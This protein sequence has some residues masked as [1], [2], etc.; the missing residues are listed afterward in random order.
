MK[1]RSLSILQNTS[2]VFYALWTLVC[3]LC[4]GTARATDVDQVIQEKAHRLV[5]FLDVNTSETLDNT[6]TR[7]NAALELLNQLETSIPQ[8]L[9]IGYIAAE[10]ASIESKLLATIAYRKVYPQLVSD[11]EDPNSYVE[12]ESRAPLPLPPKPEHISENYRL[13]WE[14]RLLIPVSPLMS[15][16]GEDVT[17]L[18]AIEGIRNTKSLMVYEWLIRRDGLLGESSPLYFNDLKWRQEVVSSLFAFGTAESTRVGL[19]LLPLINN[20]KD[21]YLSL[22]DS[23]PDV[24]QFE[25]ERL[26]IAARD[27][28]Q[29]SSKLRT[30]R[31]RIAEVGTLSFSNDEIQ[32]LH[33]LRLVDSDQPTSPTLN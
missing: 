32:T 25:Q 19:E 13:I 8:E 23:W 2:K 6:G 24:S 15:F 14:Y 5:A 20:R 26:R 27:F 12:R 4:A 18:K 22:I 30:A 21:H 29:I 1:E 11:V 7:W 9:C 10:D 3:I 28:T 16:R 31:M 33:S 17:A